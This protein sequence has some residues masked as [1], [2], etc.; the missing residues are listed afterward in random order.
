MRISEN[1]IARMIDDE[2]VILDMESGDYFALNETGVRMWNAITAGESIDAAVAAITKEF[3]GATESE[4]EADLEALVAEL[5][6]A[7]LVVD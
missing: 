7:G 5:R 2:M 6:A 4:I 3:S 1:A